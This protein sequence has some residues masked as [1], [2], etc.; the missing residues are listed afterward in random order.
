MTAF[1]VRDPDPNAVDGGRVLGLRFDIMIG[2]QF[3]RPFYILLNRDDGPKKS[4]LRIHR[5]TVPPAVPLAGLAARHLSKAGA[6]ED[7]DLYAF[8]RAVRRAIVRYHNRLAAIS[9]LRRGV[10][11]AAFEGSGEIDTDRPIDVS[12]ADAEAKQIRFDWADGRTGRLIIDDDGDIE[13]MVVIGASGTR[14]RAAARVLLG[15]EKTA[16]GLVGRMSGT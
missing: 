3:L 2:A 9:D 13:E 10:Q 4:G 5:H 8:A 16:L 1:R 6:E 14:D 7:D 15:N 11:K 12:S